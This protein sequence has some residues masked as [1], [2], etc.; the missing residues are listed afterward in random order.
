MRSLLHNSSQDFLPK[1]GTVEKHQLLWGR[2]AEEESMR[3]GHV[4]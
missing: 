4:R 3:F 1:V 2:S